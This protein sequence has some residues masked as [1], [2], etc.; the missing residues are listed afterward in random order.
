MILDSATGPPR[1]RPNE[2]PDDFVAHCIRALPHSG[3]ARALGVLSGWW[4]K[5]DHAF[6][7]RAF[8]DAMKAID[9][10][11]IALVAFADL[12][13]RGDPADGGM[14]RT[15]AMALAPVAAAAPDGAETQCVYLRALLLAGQHR[16][17]L[18]IGE[19]AAAAAGDDPMAQ[20]HLA[21][22]WTKARDPLQVRAQTDAALAR[23]TAIGISRNIASFSAFS[24][25]GRFSVSCAMPSSIDSEIASKDCSASDIRTAPSSVCAAR[26]RPAPAG[27]PRGRT[28]G[29]SSCGRCPR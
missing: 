13:L 14:A 26:P 24:V 2:A 1:A 28:P 11:G 29:S 25:S 10:D 23:A 19:Q 16:L 17:A 3:Q 9:G 22:T 5:G 15:L 12:V 7:Q 8:D 6:A 18:R 20:L 4:A 21:E 27:P